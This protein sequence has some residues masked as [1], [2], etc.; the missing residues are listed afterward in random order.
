MRMENYMKRIE[1]G[2]G[3]LKGGLQEFARVWRRAAAGER[4]PEAIPKVRFTSLAQLLSMLTPK[5]LELLDA[6]ARKPGCSIR[7]L[8]GRLGR[9]YKNVH[10]DVTALAT[11]GL[12][13][14]EAGGTLQVPYDELRITAPLTSNGKKA[15]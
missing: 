7:A 10:G 15:A 4:L 13:V 5:R 9:D 1:I 8:A 6:V 2:V 14:R 3:S 12:I 11:L